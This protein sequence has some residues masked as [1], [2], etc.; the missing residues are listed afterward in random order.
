MS[1]RYIKVAIKT[2]KEWGKSITGCT[3][4]YYTFEKTGTK[5]ELLLLKLIHLFAREGLLVKK[6]EIEETK[7]A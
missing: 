5:A 2:V 6:L 1:C 4:N 7:T 3:Y